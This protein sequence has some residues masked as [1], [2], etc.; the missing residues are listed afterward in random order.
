MVQ[1]IFMLTKNVL[2]LLNRRMV[3]FAVDCL[4][5]LAYDLGRTFPER[6]VIRFH[7]A[8]FR[9]RCQQRGK[10]LDELSNLRLIWKILFHILHIP[11][12]MG[13][14]ILNR[15]RQFVVPVIPIHHQHARQFLLAE[16]FLS[17]LRR[18]RFSQPKNTQI[19]LLAFTDKNP[20]NKRLFFY[21]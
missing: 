21:A 13:I 4:F 15:H 20:L 2:Y 5:D 16:N 14:T 10:R 19:I 9:H 6:R 8:E 12:Q 18:S 17:H 11:Q 7:L 3:G 1:P